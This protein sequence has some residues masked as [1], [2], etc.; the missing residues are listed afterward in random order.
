MIEVNKYKMSSCLLQE[1]PMLT[2]AITTDANV[3]ESTKKPPKSKLT[4][5]F[6]CEKCGK[7][8]RKQRFYEIHIKH[9]D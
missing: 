2:H 1:T 9:G 6:I 8:Y 5:P 3:H 4:K 7:S